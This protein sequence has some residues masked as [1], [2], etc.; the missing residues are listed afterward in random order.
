MANTTQI[1][2]EL[3]KSLTNFDLESAIKN[4]DNEAKTRMYLV[5]EF[6]QI[7][8]YNRG[9]EN[10]NLVPE[11]NADFGNLKNRKVDYAIQFKKKPEIIIEVK[12]VGLKLNEKH[13]SQLNDYFNNA[14]EC[15][16]GV[17]TNGVEYHFYCRNK[18]GK[19]GLHP[20]PFYS[21]DFYNIDGSSLENL[22]VF[23]LTRIEINTIIENAQEL[24]FIESFE[25]A[26][27]NELN[28]PSKDFIKSIYSKMGGSR[29]TENI[30]KQIQT[31]INSI[32]IKGA[33][34]KL[35]IDEASKANSGIITTNEELEVYNVIKTILAQNK[36]INT[37]SVGYRDLK[38]K[39]SILLDDN[40]KKKVCDLYI[41][42]NSKRIE[43]DGEKTEIPDLDSII[44]LKKK[45]TDQA[46]SFI[47]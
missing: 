26:L 11:Y 3:K 16:I 34:D 24:F 47:N 28:S 15:K 30:E 45:L 42:P 37:N 32:S 21:F 5:E 23:H 33:L 36:K 44:K 46:L 40:Q 31:L 6:F 13:L 27:Y 43:I 4:S 18:N 20:T 7:L 1:I 25:D 2:K 14:N 9:F 12:K 41:T 8:G 19:N 17:L 38:G 35:I 22:S 29:L 39:F 10:G